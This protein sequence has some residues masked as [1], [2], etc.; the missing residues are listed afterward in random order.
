MNQAYTYLEKALSLD[1]EC[2][3]EL[4]EFYPEAILDD[5]TNKIIKKYMNLP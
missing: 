1:K 3:E 2:I 4:Y 5:T